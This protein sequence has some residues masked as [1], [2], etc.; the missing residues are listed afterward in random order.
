MTDVPNSSTHSHPGT[1]DVIAALQKHWVAAGPEDVPAVFAGSLQDVSRELVWSEFW[2]TQL[3]Q[4]EQ[5]GN[6]PLQWGALID[7]HLFSRDPDK[8]RIYGLVD[9][10]TAAFSVL[11]TLSRTGQPTDSLGWLQCREPISRDFSRERAIGESVPLQ[12][13]VVSLSALVTANVPD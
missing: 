7:I 9:E 5:R 3:R 1:R 8:R 2:V 11:I 13:M 4:L 12:H 10:T 6:S